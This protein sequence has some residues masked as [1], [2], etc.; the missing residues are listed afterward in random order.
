MYILNNLEMLRILL[1]DDDTVLSEMLAEYLAPEGFNVQMAHDGEQGSQQAAKERYDAIVLD[2][3]L[4]RMNGFDVLKRIR[5]TSKVPVLMLTAKG[6]DIDRIIGLE[7]GADDYLPKPFNPRELV[8]RL[9]AI[10]RRS[11]SHQIDKKHAAEVIV[12]DD[13]D[14]YPNARTVTR[15]GIK[16]DLT[17]TEYSI[18]EVLVREAGN[19]VTKDMLSEQALGRKL[20]LHDRSLDMHISNLRRKL[21]L[22]EDKTELIETVRGIGYQFIVN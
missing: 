17:S 5:N 15:S 4:P 3:M 1:I 18:L 12:V 19:V 14:L 6:D 2:V 10:L 11:E 8:A 7:M 9:R 13:I 21:N 16:L 20:S 22:P